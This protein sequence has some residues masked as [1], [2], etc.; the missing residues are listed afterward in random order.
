MSEEMNE[1]STSRLETVLAVLLGLAAIITAF[2]AYNASLKDGDTIKAYNQ[3]IRSINDANAFYSEAVAQVTRDEGVFL[4]Y[5][6]LSQEEGTTE[7]AKYIYEALMDENLQGAVDEWQESDDLATPIDA[8]SYVVPAQAEA[9]KLEGQ[10]EARF[11]EAQ[12]LD[13]SGDRYELAGVIGAVSLF[14]LGIAGV[15]RSARM[16]VTAAAIGAVVLL[17][18]GLMTASA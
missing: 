13:D 7:I 11:A 6:K 17:V 10:T 1:R 3:G 4:E 18:A 15:F 9:E 14:F 12:S 8:E 2:A 16:K 5:A